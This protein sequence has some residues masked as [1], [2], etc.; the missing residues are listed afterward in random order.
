MKDRAEILPTLA[1]I[2]KILFCHPLSYSYISHLRSQFLQAFSL[3]STQI[4]Y[5]PT[6]HLLINHHRNHPFRAPPPFLSL[7]HGFH[8]HRK[9]ANL[10]PQLIPHLPPRHPPNPLPIPRRLLHPPLHNP[11]SHA[12]PIARLLPSQNQR[13]GPRHAAQHRVRS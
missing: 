5:P 12:R 6:L 8:L 7:H 2:E 10:P 4:P 9:R 3:V 13:C 1:I 11:H